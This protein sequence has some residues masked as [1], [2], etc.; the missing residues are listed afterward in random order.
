VP[1]PIQRWRVDRAIAEATDGQPAQWYFTAV[2][3][4]RLNTFA[5]H[6]DSLASSI[7]RFGAEPVLLT[8]AN[9]FSGQ[10][11][12]DNWSILRAW[13]GFFPKA[14][15]ETLIAFD[16]S[17]NKRI[18]SLARQGR[19]PSVDLAGGIGGERALF[20]DFSHFTTSGAARVAA[21]IAPVAS[22]VAQRD[23]RRLP[24]QP[25]QPD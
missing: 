17:A 19:Y 11:A 18:L 24:E 2:P 4:E 23:S 6:L 1:A 13:R 25:P 3:S 9:P 22:S 5:A 8:H 15:E 16:D 10:S 20:A 14:T 21:L 7:N 12:D